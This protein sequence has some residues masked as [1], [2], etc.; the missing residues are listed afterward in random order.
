MILN[1][2]VNSKRNIAKLQYD[3]KVQCD[4]IA[5]LS[6]GQIKKFDNMLLA[7]VYGNRHAHTLLIKE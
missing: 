7:G 4:T 5:H 2:T 6:Y 1:L 3:T